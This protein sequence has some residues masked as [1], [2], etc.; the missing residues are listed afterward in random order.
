M[1]IAGAERLEEKLEGVWAAVL[2]CG[3]ATADVA[4]RL[5]GAGMRGVVMNGATGEYAAATLDEVR[6]S[7][8]AISGIPTILG[9]GGANLDR[10]LALAKL[11]EERDVTALLAPVPFFF[12]YA[13]GD[14]VEFITHIAART[15]LPILLYNLPQFTTGY[16][17]QAVAAIRK[18]C[19]NVVGIKDS[20]GSLDLLRE[21]KRGPGEF[22]RILGND[23]ALAN[24]RREDLLHGLISGVASV[25]PEIILAAWEQREGAAELLQELI[26]RLSGLPTPWGLKWI[27]ETRGWFP[28]HH[29]LPL[30]EARQRE[31]AAFQTWCAG[32]LRRTGAPALPL[33]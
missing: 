24:A 20:S 8:S 14:A 5:H 12:P 25:A 1:T 7:L 15:S 10:S 32:W 33:G 3:D 17:P 27:A 13:P 28:S 18:A 31:K 9:I 29:A 4:K 2:S 26:E 19:P 22:R 21:L 16:T 6:D 23:S 11:G 30:S